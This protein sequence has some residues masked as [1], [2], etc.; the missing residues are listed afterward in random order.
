MGEISTRGDGA[1]DPALLGAQGGAVPAMTLSLDAARAGP[2]A[3]AAGSRA[4]AS[5]VERL[6][7][8]LGQ[9]DGASQGAPLPDEGGPLMPGSVDDDGEAFDAARLLAIMRSQGAQAASSTGG[10]TVVTVLGQERHLA[11]GRMPPELVSQLNANPD[12]ESVRGESKVVA[13]SAVN[14]AA[15]STQVEAG[16]D[17]TDRTRGRAGIDDLRLAP[18]AG[19]RRGA[20]FAID[21]RGQS[22]STSGERGQEGGQ[23]GGG[24]SSNG[25]QQSSGT[26]AGV[27]QGPSPQANG[28]RGSFGAAGTPHDPV[29]DQ[30]AARVREALGDDSAGET[31]PDGVVK[32]L[33]I[34]LKPANL[35]AMTLRMTLKDN[36]I[37]LQV[38]TQN[39]ETRALIEREQAKLTSTLSAAGYTVEAIT[40]VQ[41]DGLRSAGLAPTTGDP[42]ASA[43]QQQP[44]AQGQSASSEFSG[45][46][47]S[48]RPSGGGDAHSA[49][50]G[51]KDD[52]TA[53]AGRVVDGV[54]V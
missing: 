2:S 16:S 35:G 28:I 34:E 11:L 36:V 1:V 41:S 29:S 10:A 40:A 21:A 25:G 23:Q 33:N 54:Y 4:E 20:M 51:T 15:L 49:P 31:S 39:A 17:A 43:F 9:A 24:Q 13:N 8:A 14:A 37:T 47:R 46:G 22:G 38:E 7:A 32:V 48:G 6:R 53:S 19:G 26:F 3:P 27:L 12:V 42:N 44:G 50:S 30:I 18:E 5:S 52:G 45:E